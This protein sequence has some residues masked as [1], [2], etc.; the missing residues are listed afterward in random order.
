[1]VIYFVY[2]WLSDDKNNTEHKSDLEFL[3][4]IT[5]AELGHK[6][7][8]ASCGRMNQFGI[9]LGH[10]DAKTNESF[11]VA[12]MCFGNEFGAE[13][14]HYGRS[15]LVPNAPADGQ[16]P[17]QNTSLREYRYDSIGHNTLGNIPD[18]QELH[19]LI[20][21]QIE[22]DPLWQ[23]S[24]T[25]RSF[26]A[27]ERYL[28]NSHLL[29]LGYMSITAE[30][31]STSL[32]TVVEDLTGRM[33][34]RTHS[35]PV[36][37]YTGFLGARDL[38]DVVPGVKVIKVPKYVWFVARELTQGEKGIAY[39]VPNGEFLVE[40]VLCQNR[41]EKVYCCYVHDLADHVGILKYLLGLT[42]DPL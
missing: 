33:S 23:F 13:H 40:S 6:V 32:A 19:D 36:E 35:R 38:L 8:V 4:T 7:S 18:I 1:M 41:C 29:G 2:V 22:S 17:L 11:V 20:N 42:I 12:E 16:V 37:L 31:M 10:V 15:R 14:L 27:W 5:Y 39:I 9:Q 24:K 26:D 30:E 3:C 28:W 34:N 25:V 21:E